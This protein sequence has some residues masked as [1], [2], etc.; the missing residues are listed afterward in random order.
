MPRFENI[1]WLIAGHG[2]ITIGAMGPVDC[3]AT[4]A[5]QDI[6]YAMLVRH[7]GESLL[8]LLFRLD[9]SI[10]KAADNNTTIDEVNPP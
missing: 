6:C 8:E 1:E 5:D 4:A 10:A 2:D 7:N 3:A 9:R